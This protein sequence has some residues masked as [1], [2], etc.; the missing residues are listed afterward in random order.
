MLDI[1]E[2]NYIVSTQPWPLA[3]DRKLRVLSSADRFRSPAPPTVTWRITRSS[4]QDASSRPYDS[5]WHGDGAELTAMEGRA[6]IGDLAA[7]AVP[8]LVFA[9]GEPLMREDLLELVAHTHGLDIQPSLLTS[10][11]LV[12]E[13]LAAALKNAG[14][15]SAAILL[16]G[17]G[18]SHDG[19][20]SGLNAALEAYES[21]KAAGLEAEIRVLMNRQNY[22]GLAGILDVIARRQIRRV[23]F[24]HLVG[25]WR[26]DSAHADLTPDE[27]R[28]ALDLILDRA[29]NYHRR[30]VG[31][32]IATDENHADGIY[33]YLRLARRNPRRAATL[34]RMLP[35]LAANV[36]GAGVGL[37]GIDCAG[38]V[39]PDAHWD[40]VLGNVRDTPFSEIWAKS[41]DPLLRGL[42]DRLPRLKGRCANCRWKRACGGNLRVRA[43]F[44]FGDPWTTDP[45]CY[46]T[47]KEIS[48]AM[49]EQVE[50][51]EDDVL[52]L[53][54]AA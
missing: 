29:E 48:K 26:S 5:S 14:L 44:R 19:R 21:C 6:L 50:V 35:A 43:D 28:R 51:M 40:Y 30:G 41:S 20:P 17:T 8:R 39:H 36:Q 49:I 31:I 2:L 45:A 15:H 16:D 27:K 34:C 13:T 37:A 54:Q 32:E 25:E 10:G 7:C 12:T 38:Y 22:A 42:R 1:T 52:L 18:R 46:L 24:A 4:N 9:G 47:N 53:E 23:V 11:T 3:G 33:F